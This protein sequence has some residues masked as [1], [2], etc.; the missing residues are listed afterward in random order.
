MVSMLGFSCESE[1]ENVF[2]DERLSEAEHI[3]AIKNLLTTSEYGWKFLLTPDDISLGAYNMV[4]KFNADG[5][6]EMAADYLERTA[7][8]SNE[9]L[10]AT[11][12]QSNIHFEVKKESQLQLS[13]ETYSF[14]HYLYDAGILDVFQFGIKSYNENEVILFDGNTEIALSRASVEDWDMTDYLLSELYFKQFTD[15]TSLFNYLHKGDDP[16]IQIAMTMA[17]RTMAFY[18]Y[19]ESDQLRN[20]TL[21]FY[22]TKDG[23]NLIKPL[24]VPGMQPIQVIKFGTVEDGEGTS[25]VLNVFLDD[26]HESSFY[27]SVRT[28]VPVDDG[29]E[30]F[31]RIEGVSLQKGG[32]FWSC[33]PKFE[34]GFRYGDDYTFF[35]LED[36]AYFTDFS[37]YLGYYNARLNDTYN[38]FSFTFNYN[39]TEEYYDVY[40]LYETSGTDQIVFRLD[41]EKGN[42]GYSNRIDPYMREMIEGMINK[43]IQPEGYTLVSYPYANSI[44]GSYSFYMVDNKDYGYMYMRTGDLY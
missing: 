35:G 36:N 31:L 32:K 22:Y 38:M 6:C 1:L 34:K 24:V 44:D 43:M 3:D 27:S 21:G 5:T 15:N 16:K 2:P 14:I 29:I 20:Q 37:I 28:M 17:T 7:V 26:D 4:V 12:P 10:D 33:R 13:F 19:D 23:I 39:G 18:Y 11:K 40:F 42:G 9:K 25:N 8:Y 30:H 41:E